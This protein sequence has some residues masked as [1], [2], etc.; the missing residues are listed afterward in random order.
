MDGLLSND[1]KQILN[2]HVDL[3]YWQQISEIH[4]EIWV[5]LKAGICYSISATT[6]CPFNFRVLLLLNDLM[7]KILNSTCLVR[8]R[9]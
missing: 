6:F 1:V 5:G 2:G 7:H 4:V 8:V 9:C 3:H